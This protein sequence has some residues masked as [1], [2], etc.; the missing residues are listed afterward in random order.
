MIGIVN[1]DNWNRKRAQLTCD[2]LI[3]TFRQNQ[4]SCLTRKKNVKVAEAQ[5]EVE[6]VVISGDGGRGG[7]MHWLFVPVCAVPFKTI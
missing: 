6:V 4:I 7:A 5:V 3:S 2:V 1:R